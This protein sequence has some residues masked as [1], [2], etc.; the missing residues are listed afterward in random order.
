MNAAQFHNALRTIWNLDVSDLQA[1]SVIDD[2]WGTPEASSRNQIAAF[3]EDP[4]K[5]CLR[6]PDENFERLFT[7]IERRQSRHDSPSAGQVAKEG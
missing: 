4:V 7:F 1:A 5:E 3:M 2:N 6:M